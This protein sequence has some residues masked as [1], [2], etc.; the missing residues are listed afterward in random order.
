[1][2]KNRFYF[3][4]NHFR[5]FVIDLYSTFNMDNVLSRVDYMLPY[6]ELEDVDS[7]QYKSDLLEEIKTVLK[8]A[9]GVLKKYG[10]K[11]LEITGEIE[12]PREY[13]F[14]TDWVDIECSFKSGWKKRIK[15]AIPSL[16]EDSDVIEY[17]KENYLDRSGFWSYFPQTWEELERKFKAEDGFAIS[18]LLTLLLI[19]EGWDYVEKEMEVIDGMNEKHTLEEYETYRCII[20]EDCVDLY[21]SDSSYLQDSFFHKALEVFPRYRINRRRLEMGD[22]GDHLLTLLKWMERFGYCYADVFPCHENQG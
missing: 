20:P 8:E 14:Y 5:F 6:M 18:E 4:S 15:D 7:E 9:E 11:S 2:R 13:N 21:N 16:K 22:N 10:V 3:T 17:V 12:S 1:M 19:H